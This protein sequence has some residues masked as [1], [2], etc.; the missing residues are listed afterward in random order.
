M[1]NR[2]DVTLNGIDYRIRRKGEEGVIGYV[3][4]LVRKRIQRQ[5]T[6]LPGAYVSDPDR[7]NAYQTSWSR[8]SAWW[9]PSLTQEADSYYLAKNMNM[10]RRPGFIEPWNDPVE[11][12]L[13]ATHKT[14]Y[15]VNL[16]TLGGTNHYAEGNTTTVDNP[17]KDIYLW[18]DDTAAWTVTA[19][20]TGDP[21]GLNTWLY[22]AAS[23]DILMLH[24]DEIRK[25]TGSANATQL[26]S[27]GAYTATVR[28][29][30]MFFHQGRLFVYTNDV[31]LEVQDWTGT[32]AISV[33]TDDGF[34]PDWLQ[35]HA[36]AMI[37]NVR[38]AIGTAEGIY[39]VKN[40]EQAQG[41]LP[42][43]FR[44]ERD[45]AGNW[46]S[47]PIATLPL[48]SVALSIG[49]HMGSV[50]ISAAE[51]G[52]A[53]GD[54][55]V[56]P[57][58]AFAVTFYHVTGGNLGT[59][60]QPL[61]EDVA[62]E[63]PY[64]ILL[65]DGPHLYIGGQK[66]LWVYDAV[67]GGLHPWFEFDTPSTTMPLQVLQKVV[68][69][70]GSP[71][72]YLLMILADSLAGTVNEY[73]VPMRAATA[74][75]TVASFGTDLNGTYIESNYFDFDIPMEDKSI[76]GVH[77][78]TDAITTNAQYTVQV[79]VDDGAFATVATHTNKSTGY[80]FTALATPKTGKRFRYKIAYE[81]LS[82]TYA[83]PLRAIMFEGAVGAQRW[84]WTLQLDGT[85]FG[86]VENKVIRPEAAYDN[87]EALASS[88]APV[89]FVDN[90]RSERREDASTYQVTVERVEIK[91]DQPHEAYFDVTLAQTYP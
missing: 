53:V 37:G 85:E 38:L 86:N 17:N 2:F 47:V 23:T 30:N 60:G 15:G 66:R 16:A 32:P 88:G 42:H 75:A 59:L 27:L 77:I 8:G 6:G 10:W 74:L 80:S 7:A 34:G 46:N 78:L 72:P 3:K 28:G 51:E 18:D 73:Y 56:N 9:K 35:N 22:D 19:Y 41:V 83:P 39:Y 58:D 12:D 84:M 44:V 25:W 4:S 26:V 31:L 91:K 33:T 20:S 49:Y 57:R 13:V 87:I 61:G 11:T 55:T 14:L 40:I 62:D 69:N 67:R 65:A 79:A 45:G 5:D 24:S 90:F 64:Q 63:T 52:I 29:A 89:A 50:I 70:T 76:T 48:G 68:D 43:I 1:P 82:A 54:A 21:G 81:T 71:A 36:G